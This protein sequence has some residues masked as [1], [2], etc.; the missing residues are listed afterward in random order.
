M[1]DDSGRSSPAGSSGA[2]LTLITLTTPLHLWRIVC[3]FGP[4]ATVSCRQFHV[5]SLVINE[6]GS[7]MKEMLLPSTLILRPRPHRRVTT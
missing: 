6:F 2:S 5:Q 7:V 1:H 3:T 4:A